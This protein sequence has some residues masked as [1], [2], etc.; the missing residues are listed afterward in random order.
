MT[1]LSPAPGSA[2]LTF[3]VACTGDEPSP[4]APRH[5]VAIEADWS[6][7]LPH[8]LEAERIALAFGAATP[9]LDL[10]AHGGAALR[11]LLRVMTRDADDLVVTRWCAL[12]RCVGVYAHADAA[13]AYRH[14]V[15]ARHLAASFDLRAWQAESLIVG[16]RDA[17]LSTADPT[18]VTEGRLGYAELWDAAVLPQVV[19]EIAADLP[20]VLL[21]L[22][23]QFFV[24]VFHD[25]VDRAWLGEILT[26]FPDRDLACFLAAESR[27][28]GN[29]S[30]REALEFNDLGFGPS[31]VREA[32]ESG[33]T[34]A[35]V[36]QRLAESGDDSVILLRW[37]AEW[38]RVGCHPRE[39]HFEILASHRIPHLMPGR[40]EIDGTVALC[41]L[42]QDNVDRTEVAIMLAILGEPI[43]VADAFTH[44]IT[45][46]RDLPR[47]HT[48]PRGEIA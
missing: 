45:A 7:S 8:D 1:V 10:A 12:G 29:L 32:I 27:R 35:L 2:A 23:W 33:T 20:E 26:V 34:A 42:V 15:T 37:Q 16:A 41:R 28:Y 39:D 40:A 46:A 24:D 22:P 5:W 17:W 47:H 44:G 21:P 3:E 31:E 6:V 13:A 9:C 38:R 30:L 43:G 14:E 18:L 11:H 25:R 36:R 4:D 19:A 48:A